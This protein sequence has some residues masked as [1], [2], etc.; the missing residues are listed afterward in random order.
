MNPYFSPQ[1]VLP[2][3]VLFGTPLFAC[4]APSAGSVRSSVQAMLVLLVLLL[5]LLLSCTPLHKIIRDGIPTS[6]ALL[7]I[8]FDTANSKDELVHEDTVL[9]I[10]KL[11]RQAGIIGTSSVSTSS[12]LQSRVDHRAK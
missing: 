10:R 6:L 12:L 4:G 8:N 2:I 7:P 3:P 11:W 5:Y 1:G 9:T